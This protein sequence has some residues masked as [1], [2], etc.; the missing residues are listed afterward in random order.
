MF[1]YTESQQRRNVSNLGQLN[2]VQIYF[3]NTVIK[4][5]NRHKKTAHTY[6]KYLENFSV[7][8]LQHWGHWGSLHSLTRPLLRL[9]HVTEPQLPPPRR[10]NSVTGALMFAILGEGG[11]VSYFRWFYLCQWDHVWSGYRL[12]LRQETETQPQI[13]MTFSFCFEAS[14]STKSDK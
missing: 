2:S 13:G 3:Q 12:K 6:V 7:A 11:G 9:N 10:P 4:D 8:E 5:R 14:R 1:Y